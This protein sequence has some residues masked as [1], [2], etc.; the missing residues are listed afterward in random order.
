[1]NSGDTTLKY[2]PVVQSFIDTSFFQELSRLKLEF[3]KLSQDSVPLMANLDPLS[4][5]KLSHC[6]PLCL[7]KQSFHFENSSSP[8]NETVVHGE[9]F[10]FNKIEEFIDLK[11]DDFIKE[12]GLSLY[13]KVQEDINSCFKFVVITFADLKKYQY[14]YWVVVPCF[15]PNN[16][17]ISILQ[18]YDATAHVDTVSQW[19]I[20]NSQNWVG[21]MMADGCITDYKK[22]TKFKMV[23]IRDTSNL[24]H[25][26]SMLA[27]NIITVI[28][29]DYPE[30]QELIVYFH[31]G[32]KEDSFAL[33]LKIDIDDSADGTLQFSGWERNMQ[34][35]LKPR[36]IDLSQML[37]TKK[38]SEQAVDLNLKLMKWRIVPEL[39]LD[40]IKQSRILILGAG[41]LGC[42][43]SRALIAWGVQ[44]ITFVDNGKIS[45]S[46]P[47][48]QSLFNFEDCGKWKAEVAAHNLRKISPV[49]DAK[50]I[51]LRIPMIGHPI[52]NEQEEK[53][54]YNKLMELISENDIVYLLM[55]SRETR[56]LPTVLSNVYSKIVI[57]A[58]IGFD[59]YLVMRHG[60]YIKN[61]SSE[62]N[63]TDS[64][65]RLSCYFCQDVMVPTNS[66]S[67]KTLDQM[68]TV[69]RPGAA[70]MA[71]AQAVELMVP[72][73]QKDKEILGEVPH[74][75]RGFLHNFKTLKL[76]APAYKYCSA[77][78]V[79]VVETCREMN[80]DFVKKALLENDYIEELSGLNKVKKDMEALVSDIEWDEEEE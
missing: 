65:K 9:I 51:R 11:R 59:S 61:D 49:V 36:L 27:K 38:L 76:E 30:L 1:M 62:I 74:Q 18:L 72:L 32:I 37:D 80:W 68:C 60:L 4:M 58:A 54:S 78:S 45:F 39:D 35:K 48:R 75:I 63:T 73:L 22:D 71:A 13:Q 31:R 8:L 26:P 55:D 41:T 14:V 42:Y 10:N 79:P 19:F 3:W 40:I 17:N 7:D 23:C 25:I 52:I 53:E 15:I 28:H 66:S 6:L 56:W 24:E 29:K 5:T 21:L 12:Q 46:N 50:G 69:T 64:D 47:V 44:S 2:A 34:G 70:I 20:D 33:K 67:D 43:V 77:C 57:N 16:L